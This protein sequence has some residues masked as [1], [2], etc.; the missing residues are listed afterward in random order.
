MDGKK[1]GVK[2]TSSIDIEKYELNEKPLSGS[3]STESLITNSE[4]HGMNIV[5]EALEKSSRNLVARPQNKTFTSDKIRDIERKNSILMK[6]ILAHSQRSNRF[7]AAPP[8]QKISSSALN[9]KKKDREISQDNLIL[10]RKIQTV[11]PFGLSLP[12]R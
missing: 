1:V 11:K 7:A 3:N 12:K 5:M 6:K 9:R 2:A 4:E 8:T 10:L